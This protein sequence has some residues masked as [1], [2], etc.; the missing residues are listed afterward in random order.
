MVDINNGIINSLKAEDNKIA[1]SLRYLTGVAHDNK[2]TYGPIAY[3]HTQDPPLL[4]KMN[5]GQILTG[6]SPQTVVSI[7]EDDVD[8]ME[9]KAWQAQLKD[10]NNWVG[11]VYRPEENPANKELLNR[12]YPQFI[13]QQKAVIDNWHDMK[14][15]IETLKLKG[16]EN[17]ED[18]FLLYRLF[19]AK[20]NAEIVDPYSA[21]M[22]DDDQAPG[23][24]TGVTAAQK[25]IYENNFKRG[26]GSNRKRILMTQALA[27]GPYSNKGDWNNGPALVAR[28]AVP[29]FNNL[30]GKFYSNNLTVDPMFSLA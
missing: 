25:V 22:L 3:N 20:D 12:I 18:L 8:I 23:L 24:K 28:N 16:A 15:R 7:T 30:N 1:S 2:G 4:D 6:Q 27:A 21:K 17:K 13:E 26:L 19:G 11:H 29:P 9:Q 14:K 10:F 5:M